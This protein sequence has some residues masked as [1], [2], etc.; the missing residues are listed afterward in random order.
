L[1]F[2]QGVETFEFTVY[3]LLLPFAFLPGMENAYVTSPADG[4][5]L[6]AL[7]WPSRRALT[8]PRPRVGL[9]TFAVEFAL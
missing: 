9:L 4:I 1:C 2:L 7:P 6:G 8:H 3:P 5:E